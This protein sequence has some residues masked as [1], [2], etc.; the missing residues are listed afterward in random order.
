MKKEKIIALCVLVLIVLGF[1]AYKY[2]S[3][4]S[5][6]LCIYEI[7]NHIKLECPT[8]NDTR[9]VNYF[10]ITL[11]EYENGLEQGCTDLERLNT[12]G[13]RYEINKCNESITFDVFN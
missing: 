3:N 1:G 9:V 10:Q 12:S 5:S 11:F 2:F 6:G 4:N 7:P 13:Y 8:G